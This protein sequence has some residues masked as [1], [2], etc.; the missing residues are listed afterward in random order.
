[1]KKLLTF[2]IWLPLITLGQQTINGSITHAGLQ[3][4]YI[5]HIPSSYNVNTPIPL[6]FCFHGYGSNASTIM[7]YTNFN[8][9]SDTAGFIV[10]Y[11]Q[12]TLLQ[13]TTHWN[14]GGWTIGSTIDD[15]GFTASLLDSISNSYN[16]DDTKV[17]STGMSNGGY[18]SFLLACQL[19]DKIAAIASV[20]GSM[21]TQTYNACNPQHP[22]PILQIHGT[23]DQTVPY[24]GDPTWTKSIDDVLQY[25]VA[26]N[27]CNTSAIITAIADINIFDGSTAEHIV[28][29][30]GDNNVTTKHLKIYGGDHDWP[31]VWGNMDIHASA[32]VWKFFSR[33]DINGLIST[34]TSIKEKIIKDKRLVKIT[35]ILGRETTTKNNTLL[36]Y[37]YNDETVEKKIVI[38]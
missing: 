12:G 8:Y 16:I 10:V 24:I 20:T 29:D 2:L 17:Y 37:I 19:S 25:W 11:P 21:T 31:G 15:V 1:M 26:Y 28:Y 9:I 38:K 34:S 35:D 22:T 3:R 7:S 36:F 32:E 27:N 4:D 14:V 23:S 33:Y 18:M 5:I 6:V 13:G 30:G